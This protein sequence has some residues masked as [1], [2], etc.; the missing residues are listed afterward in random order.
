M[1]ENDYKIGI[2][3]ASCIM[4]LLVGVIVGN[5]IPI[6]SYKPIE[7]DFEITVNDGKADTLFIYRRP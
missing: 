1:N 7:P 5:G 2:A 4:C 3:V 6:Q